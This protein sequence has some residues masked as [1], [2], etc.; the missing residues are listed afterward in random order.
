[1]SHGKKSVKKG[2][3][4][5]PAGDTKER[6]VKLDVKIEPKKAVEKLPAKKIT[7]QPKS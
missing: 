3:G 5:G 7:S 1:M 4:E 6:V 2:E